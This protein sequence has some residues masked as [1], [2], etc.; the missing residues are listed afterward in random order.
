MGWMMQM[1]EDAWRS[2]V[3]RAGKESGRQGFTDDALLLLTAVL[4]ATSL[5]LLSAPRP[6]SLQRR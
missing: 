1:L 4:S 5:I 3:E 2:A 6:L